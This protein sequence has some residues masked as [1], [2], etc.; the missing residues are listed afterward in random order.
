M[1]D[2][3]QI[4]T[5]VRPLARR[6]YFAAH[7]VRKL[8]LGCGTKIVPGW[9]NA[10]KFTTCADMY[11]D[12]YRRLP[13]PDRSFRIIYCEHL[14]EHLRIDRVPRFLAEARRVLEDGGLFRLSCPDLE[15]FAA[16]Y[17]AGDRDFFAPILADFTERQRKTPHAKY[18][19]VRSPGGAFM[20]RAMHFH[21]HRWMY[22]FETLR[23]CLEEVGFRRVLKQAYRRSV[24]EEAGA[25]DGPVRDW[26][27][28]Y[29][30]A[31]R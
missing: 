22:D 23:S 30:D 7:P 18:W 20:S 5:L 6:R 3:V 14:I 16:R 10:D 15:L 31:L 19:V 28:L 8:H 11:V 24:V 26:E 4:R 1:S 9:L 2:W 13:F 27:S 12:A 21:N 25:M 29:V 17:V